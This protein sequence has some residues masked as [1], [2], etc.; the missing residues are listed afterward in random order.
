MP[1]SLACLAAASGPILPSVLEPSE[2]RT[3]AVD[4]LPSASSP[5]VA[6]DAQRL[7]DG[8]A[9]RGAAADLERVERVVD[10]RA[11]LGR[12][13]Q[14]LRGAR[15]R[16]DAHAPA[17]RQL[18]QHPPRRGP[19]GREAVGLDVRGRHRARAVDREHDRGSAAR[20]DRR[21]LRPRGADE[22]RR[23]RQ[24]PEERRHVAP[25][26]RPAGDHVRHQ[27]GIAEPDGG[28]ALAAL[29]ERVHDG[30]DGDR[31]Q[32]DEHDRPREVVAHGVAQG[33]PVL[34]HGSLPR[35]A[36]PSAPAESSRTAPAAANAQV[37]SRCSVVEPTRVP[38]RS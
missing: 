37:T 10:E 38:M 7:D 19:G 29:H 23:Q 27:R 2:S 25:P 32:A 35:Q 3:I 5:G 21:L 6:G 24:Q 30:Q 18:R 26:S 36:T 15:E 20:L 1:L 4:G 31:Q 17:G 11:V 12:G 14:R 28:A 13:R 8:V 16:D 22:Q 9:D 33:L 34:V